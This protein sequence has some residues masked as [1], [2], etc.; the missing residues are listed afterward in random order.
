MADIDKE[1]RREATKESH[2][3]VCPECGFAVDWSY[4]NLA[5]NGNPVCDCNMEMEL[6]D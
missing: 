3:W 4:E 1:Q 2:T 6:Q 5:K